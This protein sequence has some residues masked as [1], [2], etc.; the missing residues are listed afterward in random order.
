MPIAHILTPARGLTVL[1]EVF[2]FNA[3]EARGGGKYNVTF[4]LTDGNSSITVKK[5]SLSPEDKSALEK[6]IPNGT[7]IALRGYAKHDVRKEVEDIDLTFYYT[8]LAVVKKVEREV[9]KRM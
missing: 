6:L 3:E 5:F 2:A 1:G 4:C 7:A 9:G 8:D